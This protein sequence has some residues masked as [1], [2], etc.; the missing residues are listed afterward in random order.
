LESLSVSAQS[1]FR[2]A[3]NFFSKSNLTSILDTVLIFEVVPFETI[4][5]QVRKT[6][7]GQFHGEVQK[8]TVVI[9]NTVEEIE[10]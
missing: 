3:N 9:E 2:C 4:T 1:E 7:Q 5:V 6:E 10:L 8:V